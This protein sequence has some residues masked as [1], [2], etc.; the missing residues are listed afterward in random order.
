MLA[1]L[2]L[3]YSIYTYAADSQ[4]NLYETIKGF[5]AVGS[6]EG[7]SSNYGKIN[8]V[9]LFNATDISS[10]QTFWVSND[11]STASYSPWTI[12]AIIAKT[13]Q[14]TSGKFTVNASSG[15]SFSSNKEY[16][17]IPLYTVSGTSKCKIGAFGGGI[18]M[19]S[20]SASIEVTNKDPQ[21][22][23]I[24]KINL[25]IRLLAIKNSAPPGDGWGDK[26][27]A[28]PENQYITLIYNTKNTCSIAPLDIIFEY[29]NMNKQSILKAPPLK[30]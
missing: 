29:P 28:L 18:I 24:Q 3:T 2:M 20:G 14:A 22:I 27:D 11:C 19:S 7:I 15:I 4:A 23:G 10:G 5:S 17:A 8:A 21:P 13:I 6:W 1:V 25:P 16:L 12:Y 26:G 9:V 30:K